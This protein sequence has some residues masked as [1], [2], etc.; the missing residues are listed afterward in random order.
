MTNELAKYTLREIRSVWRYDSILA[1]IEK[2]L[3]DISDEIESILSPSCPL[4]QTGPKIEHSGITKQTIINSLLSDEMELMG[5][6]KKFKR[7]K[8]D[9]EKMRIQFL[10]ACEENEFD[11]GLAV[12]DG[13]P[14]AKIEKKLGYSNAFDH[15]MRICKTLK[16]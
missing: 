7:L 1:G 13:V 11:F 3:K 15:A 10:A 8:N 4:G 14:Y 12:V 16:Y 2:D 5:R 6:Q 9:A